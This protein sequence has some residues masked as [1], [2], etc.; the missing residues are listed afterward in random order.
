M[1]LILIFSFLLFSYAQM[2]A[3]N[4]TGLQEPEK[5]H[6]C[7]IDDAFGYWWSFQSK[8]EGTYSN[9]PKDTGG[10]TMRG[11]TLDTYIRLT[12]KSR[13]EFLQM[14]KEEAEYIAYIYFYQPNALFNDDRINIIIS[15][16]F[17]G[18]GGYQ[19]VKDMQKILNIHPDGVI[20]D[21]TIM[22]AN[23]AGPDLFHKLVNCR[24]R[25]MRNCWNY[26]I[27]K[28]GYEKYITFIQNL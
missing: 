14:S 26:P 1:K 21:L 8:M 24:T 6:Q 20:G 3:P 28:G 9:H 10:E 16:S 13:A 18:G 27:F 19:L 2:Y 12:K 11:I 25:Y 22:A 17:W 15:S 5:Q 7:Y 23:E 4:Q